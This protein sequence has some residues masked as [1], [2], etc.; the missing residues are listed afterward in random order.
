MFSIRYRMHSIR[1]S[2][3]IVRIALVSVKQIAGKKID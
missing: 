2:M 1:H 3:V